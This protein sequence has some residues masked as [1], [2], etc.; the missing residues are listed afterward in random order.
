M[1]LTYLTQDN[2]PPGPIVKPLL[3][4]D[5][6]M[7]RKTNSK[8][9]ANDTFSESSRPD[10][11]NAAVVGAATLSAVDESSFENRSGVC[12]L[13]LYIPLTLRSPLSHRLLVRLPLVGIVLLDSVQQ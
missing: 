13:A 1:D 4:H 11:F 7:K 3:L 8:P 10:G 2:T 5:S 9:K 12:Y 6:T